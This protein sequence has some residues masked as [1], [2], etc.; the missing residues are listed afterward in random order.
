MKKRIAELPTW[1]FELD[2]V[3][4][5]VYE[6]IGTDT[7]GHRVSAKGTDPDSL[8][9]QCRSD[10]A[11]LTPESRAASRSQHSSRRQQQTRARR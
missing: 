9:E 4:A 3:S 5:G 11:R 1:Q 8:F 7:L 2:E 6:V 10:A